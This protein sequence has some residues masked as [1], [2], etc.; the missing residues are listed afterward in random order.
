MFFV[1]ALL[2]LFLPADPIPPHLR[3]ALQELQRGHLNEAEAD[4]NQVVGDDASNAIAWV[5][6]AE[7]ERRLGKADLAQS[8]AEKAE[9]AGAKNPLVLHSLGLYYAASN[10]PLKA[11]QSEEQAASYRQ[12]AHSWNLAAEYYLKAGD[13]ADAL[14]AAKKAT[15]ADPGSAFALAQ[16]F[17]R[18]REFNAASEILEPALAARP[19]DAQLHLAFGVTRYG[20]RRFEEA[21][22]AFIE[23]ARLDPSMSQPYE[24]LGRVLDQAGSQ[25]GVVEGLLERH[26]QANPNDAQA[27]L[28]LAK[29]LLARDPSS[30]KA[31]ALLRKAVELNGRDWESRYELGTVL[32]RKHDYE[33]AAQEL[34]KATELNPNDAA[35]HYHLARVYDR[36][37]DKEKAA[38]ERTVH[39]QL[40]GGKTQ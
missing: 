8:A 26:Q 13:N 15:S 37:G 22:S 14:R 18:Q 31:E 40:T 6:L 27:N 25:A 28:L 10:Q 34:A 24:F 19:D 30:V 9:R 16:Q 2:L 38:A 7:V 3:Q 36:L 39:A 33:A 32:E 35:P 17:L 11:A 29:A 20:Q 1:P 21:V 12:D 4:L 5:S 23:A